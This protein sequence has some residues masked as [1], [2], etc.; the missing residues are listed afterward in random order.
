VARRREVVDVQ[1]PAGR[2]AEDDRALTTFGMAADPPTV[3]RQ[4]LAEAARLERLSRPS[5]KFVT[6]VPV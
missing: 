6:A 4:V 3:S 5:W 2:L 1:E